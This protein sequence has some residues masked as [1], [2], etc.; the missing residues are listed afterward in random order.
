[1]HMLCL[2]ALRMWLLMWLCTIAQPEASSGVR[3]T[4]HQVVIW[5]YRGHIAR[6]MQITRTSPTAK[7]YPE[8]N[9]MV[10]AGYSTSP[11]MAVPLYTKSLYPLYFYPQFPCTL[12]TVSM[13]LSPATAALDHLPHVPDP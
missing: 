10:C 12:V 7:A 4:V 13:Y 3:V 2:L 9:C 6:C 8:V 11:T 1:M 5:C